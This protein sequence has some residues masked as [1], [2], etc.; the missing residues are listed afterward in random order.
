MSDFFT[1]ANRLRPA[2]LQGDLAACEREIAGE[3]QKLPPGPFHIAIDLSI[4]SDPRAAAGHFDRFF[5]RE[6][7]RFQI[8]AACTEMNGFDINPDRWFCDLFAYSADGGHDQYDWLSDWQSQRFEDFEIAGF[9]PLQEVYAGEARRDKQNRGARDLSSLIV[10]VK[11]Q[12][13]IQQAAAHMKMLRFPL[14]ATGHD[15]DF[16]ASFDPRPESAR[17]PKGA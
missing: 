10:V 1:M 14:Y 17:T 16:I 5:D 3:M 11:F 2:L 15:F 12:R 6:S 8:A 4:T 9:E 7:N 13:F